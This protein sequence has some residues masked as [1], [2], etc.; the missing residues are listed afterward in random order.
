[1][2]E[3]GSTMSTRRLCGLSSASPR[4]NFPA[5]DKSHNLCVDVV[6]LYFSH[7]WA[8]TIQN[9]RFPTVPDHVGCHGNVP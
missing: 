9:I 4:P 8:T 3:A 1:M 7:S 5:E 6:V 2:V